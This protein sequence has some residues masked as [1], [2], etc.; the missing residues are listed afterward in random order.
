[1]DSIGTGF[2]INGQ[3][4]FATMDGDQ[5]MAFLDGF[6]NIIESECGF[7]NTIKDAVDELASQLGMEVQDGK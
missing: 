7:G 4:V 2:K 6:E 3:P 5:W 1:M